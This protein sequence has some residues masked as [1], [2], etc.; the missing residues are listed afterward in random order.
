MKYISAPGTRR[1]TLPC[2]FAEMAPPATTL[3]AASSTWST[4]FLS[5]FV[6]P[7]VVTRSAAVGLL[8]DVDRER[9]EDAVPLHTGRQLGRRRGQG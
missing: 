8:L 2:P 3:A 6:P 4:R 1:L 9:G 5:N 7:L